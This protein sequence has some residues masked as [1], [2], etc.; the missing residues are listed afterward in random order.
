VGQ[1]RSRTADLPGG[2]ERSEAPWRVGS[3]PDK[4][5]PLLGPPPRRVERHPRDGAARLLV[6]LAKSTISWSRL[7]LAS[8][9]ISSRWGMVM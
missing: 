5:F 7:L 4:R 9:D 8:G 3:S 2:A 1:G 6:A